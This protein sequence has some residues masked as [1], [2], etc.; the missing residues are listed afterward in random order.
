[1]RSGRTWARGALLASLAA[2]LVAG[3]PA[4][5]DGIPADSPFVSVDPRVDGRDSFPGE[6]TAALRQSDA[7]VDPATL[8]SP[9]GFFYYENRTDWTAT[10]STGNV[11]TYPGSTFFVAHDIFGAATGLFTA[12]RS[13]DAGDWNYVKVTM[14]N[15]RVVECWNFAGFVGNAPP[16]A[17]LNEPDDGL[18]ITDAVGLGSSSLIPEGPGPDLIDD[19]GF[20]ARLDGDPLTDRHWFPGDPEPGDPGWDWDDFH[21]CFARAGFNQTF[22]ATGTDPDPLHAFD[23]ET[24][25]WCFHA[26]AVSPDPLQ[27]LEWEV[28]WVDPPKRAVVFVAPD[29]LIHFGLPPVPAFPWVATLALAP[30][31]GALGWW[32]AR[33]AT[34]RGAGAALVVLLA[35]GLSG[36][37][38]SGGGEKGPPPL[39][40][41]PRPPVNAIPTQNYQHQLQASGQ[42]PPFTYALAPGSSL[43]PGLTLSPGG[44]I[45]GV[46]PP[47]GGF[48][49]FFDVFISDALGSSLTQRTG[50]RVEP[51][52]YVPIELVSLSL[53]SVSPI[54]VGQVGQESIG[55]V[56][57]RGGNP[58]LPYTFAL[59]PGHN[60]PTGLNLTPSGV[61][62]GI[63]SVTANPSNAVQ[64]IVT[65]GATNAPLNLFF[66]V[67]P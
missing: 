12:F 23:H 32:L 24:Y 28:V 20:I 47:P 34:R 21:G 64:V 31:L 7:F 44:L 16:H 55:A 39:E 35:A 50:I 43:P 48:T 33:R 62:R 46:V 41:D 10:S 27:C 66:D 6:W 53:Q 38:G 37:G 9:A 22:Q 59:A 25:E 42:S 56:R 17:D 29:F 18:W 3:G 52:P 36:C 1:M 67:V 49:S 14:S 45:A 54:L 60:L 4:A 30:L 11:A 63:P 40:R 13:N 65:N 15:G 5:G 61:V 8:T 51:N 19:R 26:S 58:S 57:I 2:V